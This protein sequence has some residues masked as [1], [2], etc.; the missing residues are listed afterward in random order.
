[1]KAETYRPH[2]QNPKCSL[3]CLQ[4][5]HCSFQALKTDIEKLP[6]FPPNAAKRKSKHYNHLPDSKNCLLK[7][8]ASNFV[9]PMLQKKQR[10]LRT[11]P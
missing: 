1:V 7:K 2:Q 6:I 3:N 8:A 4:K 10:A 5:K 9:N 11:L